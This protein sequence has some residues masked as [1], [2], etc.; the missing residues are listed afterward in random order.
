MRLQ[1]H[2]Q[3][4]QYLFD[5]KAELKYLG[6]WQEE[7][8]S[9]AAL[10]SALPFCHDTLEFPQWLQFVLISR[11]QSLID[12]SAPLPEN[13]GIVPYAEEYFKQST[14]DTKKLLLHLAKIDRLLSDA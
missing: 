1:K 7:A 2:K 13:C 9:S 12:V 6:L 5:I 8:P 11:L 3:A 14:A 4:A 10:S